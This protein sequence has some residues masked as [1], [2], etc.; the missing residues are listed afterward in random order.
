MV[1]SSLKSSFAS[2]EL[3][4][5]GG[6]FPFRLIFSRERERFRVMNLTQGRSNLRISKGRQICYLFDHVLGSSS[7]SG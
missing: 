7:L 4:F 5:L 3:Q 2:L 6:E 1:L